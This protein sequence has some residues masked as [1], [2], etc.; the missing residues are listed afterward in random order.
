M[1]RTQREV[2]ATNAER[3]QR[4]RQR[5][6]VAGWWRKPCRECGEAPEAYIAVR[7][8]FKREH[9]KHA[10]FGNTIVWIDGEYVEPRLKAGRLV[11]PRLPA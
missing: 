1:T 6:Q 2:R 11:V 9:A 7:G 10:T 8:P 4:S 3:A 5:R